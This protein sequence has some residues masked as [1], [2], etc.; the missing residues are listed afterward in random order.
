[1][2]LPKDQ[3]WFPAKKYGY[4]WGL[5]SKW[6]GWTVMA[7]YVI[8]LA[9]GGFL[10]SIHPAIFVVYAVSISAVLYL[11]CSR[12]GERAAWRWGG[13]EEPRSSPDRKDA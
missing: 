2:P 10:V 4:G 6:Q 11:I 1:M 7:G 8:A 12:K 13:V 5:P 9:L 3:A